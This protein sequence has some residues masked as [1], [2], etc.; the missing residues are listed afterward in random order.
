MVNTHRFILLHGRGSNSERI[1]NVFLQSIDIS[2]RLPTVKFIFPTARKR[3]STVLKRIPIHQWFDNCSLEDPNTCTELQVDGLEGTSE[4][5][6]TLVHQEAETMSRRNHI[7]ENV[8]GDGNGYRRVIVGGLSQGC[9]AVMFC[10][11]GGFE[12]SEGGMVSRLGG[13]VGMNGWLPFEREIARILDME[14]L[15]QEEKDENEDEDD[16]FAR[17]SDDAEGDTGLSPRI[18]ALNHMRD[19]LDLPPIRGVQSE[20]K[21]PVARLATPV[22]LGHGAAD[23]KVSVD[24]GRRMVA[25]LTAGL[26]M[27][28]TWKAYEEFGHWYKVPE[29]IDDILKILEEKVG[30]LVEQP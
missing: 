29:E 27:D 24:L 30:V 13:F 8:N 20:G 6:R 18:Q 7:L 15:E 28:V 17:D 3:R 16:P 22:S 25:I 26:G 19:L 12:G 5:L 4:L 1:G 14:N 21:E 10:L 11:L 23:P 9:V 2:Q